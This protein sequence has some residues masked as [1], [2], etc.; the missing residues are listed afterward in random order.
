M[1]RVSVPT[2]LNERQ[3]W[4][5]TKDEPQTSVD[6]LLAVDLYKMELTLKLMCDNEGDEVASEVALSVMDWILSDSQKL[7]LV[8][9]IMT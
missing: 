8:Y 1:E 6:D 7:I 5:L 2:E 4:I 9:M 3:R